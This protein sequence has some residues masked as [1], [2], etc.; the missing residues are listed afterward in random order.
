MVTGLIELLPIE[1]NAEKVIDICQKNKYTI[2][3]NKTE[4]E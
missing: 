2:V 3:R 4:G 1:E